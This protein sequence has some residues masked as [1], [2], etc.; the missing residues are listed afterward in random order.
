[1]LIRNYQ[2]GDEDVQA[3][4]YNAAAGSLPA[5]KP[6]TAEEIARRYRTTDPD[7]STKFYAIDNGRVVG[8]A[9]FSPNGRISF[10]W[11]LPEAQSAEKPLLDAVCGALRQHNAQAAWAAYRADWR[12][13]G[14][15]LQLYGFSHVRSMVNYVAEVSR[16]PHAP[17]P[18]DLE[19]G[20]LEQHEAAEALRMAGNVL[21]GDPVADPARFFWE[22]SA[23]SPDGLLA[24]RERGTH[25]LLGAAV[26]VIHSGY[27]DP[28][29]IN[30]AMPCFRL[31][32][33]GTET[34]RHKRVN[35]LVS[36]VFEGAE[37]GERLLA[38]AARRIAK[39]G[40]THAAAQAASDQEK[41]L[42]LYDKYM[43]RQ[44]SFPI[45]ARAL[46]PAHD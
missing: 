11:C 10:P 7:P 8:Y 14:D 15:R 35:G 28:T 32:T 42:R 36:C 12:T 29:Q 45:L 41:T 43:D 3:A 18:G 20:P 33:W 5:F 16:L 37:T 44:G 13:I 9:V 34:Q 27:A 38:E 6:A 17:L 19:A 46:H 22:S 31:G 23:L 4:I 24:V 39:A 21:P 2:P 1:M 25:R 30:A 26:V 40:L